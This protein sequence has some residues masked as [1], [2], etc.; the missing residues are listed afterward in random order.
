MPREYD[1]PHREQWNKPIHQMLK[2]IDN[3]T[4]EYLK[5]GDTWH[6]KQAEILRKYVKDLKEWIIHQENTHK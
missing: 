6:L 1:T 5:D 2:A 3:H 4:K